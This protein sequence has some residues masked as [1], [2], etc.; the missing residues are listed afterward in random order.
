MRSRVTYANVV[1]SLA[2]FV[3]LGGT[4]YAALKLPANSVG[5]KQ[6]KRKAVTNA[7]LRNNAVTS[8]KVR[9]RTLLATDFA[10]GQLPQ[11]ARG[12]KGDRGDTGAPGATGPMGPAVGMAGGDT[13][14]PNAPP[15]Y[16]LAKRT[17]TMPVAGSLFVTARATQG[18][19]T[20]TGM[21]CGGA[22]FGIFVDGQP[23]PGTS[24]RAGSFFPGGGG[25]WNDHGYTAFGVMPGLAAGEHTVMLG[26]DYTYATATYTPGYSQVGAIALG[27]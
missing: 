4:G 27:G 22:V 11:G 17:I 14:P 19:G 9:D 12:E 25:S 16:E 20:C 21:P 8:R 7:K 15:S 1:S 13:L 18:S 5:S 24:G 6:I 10:L 2:L 26:W 23:V 3:A